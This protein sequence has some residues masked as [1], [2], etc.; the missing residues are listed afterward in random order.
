MLGQKLGDSSGRKGEIFVRKV[1]KDALKR[2]KAVYF[3]AQL[4]HDTE[5]AGNGSRDQ[6][7]A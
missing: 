4:Q 3:A 7:R 2:G 1:G 6:L 5:N